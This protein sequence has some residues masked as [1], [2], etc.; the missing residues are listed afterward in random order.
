MTYQNTMLS[1]KYLS[2]CVILQNKF[3]KCANL[4]KHYAFLTGV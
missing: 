3:F 2:V 1:P 4:P